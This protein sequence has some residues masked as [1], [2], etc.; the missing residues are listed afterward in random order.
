[1]SFDVSEH[2]NI[3]NYCTDTECEKLI[4]K[5]NHLF[6][7]DIPQSLEYSLIYLIHNI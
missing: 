2:C 4:L 6:L 1:M 7:M 3:S 5:I